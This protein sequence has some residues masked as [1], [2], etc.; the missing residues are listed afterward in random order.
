MLAALRHV[1]C[2]VDYIEIL[3][4]VCF[5]FGLGVSDFVLFSFAPAYYCNF[6]N[7]SYSFHSSTDML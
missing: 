5:V 3:L 7:I 6:S 1:A 4:I 2:L